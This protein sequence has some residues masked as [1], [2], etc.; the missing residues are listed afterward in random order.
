MGLLILVQVVAG[1]SHLGLR[2]Q[3]VDV[4]SNP[5]EKDTHRITDLMDF[6]TATVQEI[7]SGF[8]T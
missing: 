4:L 8:F 5:L 7:F 1:T 2:R 6:P 3:K